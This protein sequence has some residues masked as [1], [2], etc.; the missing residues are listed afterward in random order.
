MPKHKNLNLERS[1]EYRKPPEEENFLERFNAQLI[2]LERSLY[3]EAEITHPFLFVIGLPRSG[4]TLLTQVLA[5]CLET[6]FVNNLAARFWRNPVTGIRF[7]RAVLDDEPFQAFHSH[8]G[9]TEKLKDIHEFGYF[10]REWLRKEDFENIKNAGEAEERIDWQG[11]RRV[12]ANMQAEFG[13]P[14]VF[15]NIYGSYHMER[16][17][18]ILGKTLWIRIRRN[19]LDTAVS[20][21]KARKKYYDDPGHWWSYVPPEYEKIIDRDYWHQIAGQIYYLD[22][23]YRREFERMGDGGPCMEIGYDELCADPGG[24][25]ERINAKL[26]KHHGGEAAVPVAEYPPSSFRRSS[27]DDQP[28]LKKRFEKLLK[29]FREHDEQQG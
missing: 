14:M 13:R 19:P 5:H 9:S 17:N 11:L 22:R 23:F 7:A 21:L 16:L 8:Y 26:K 1:E 4:T 15:K 28:E 27:H 3:R 2:P 18:R 25:L 12:L 20:I 10:W 29:K 24:Q 6:G